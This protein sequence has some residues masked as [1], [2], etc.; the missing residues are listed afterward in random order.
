MTK[1]K[2]RSSS[3]SQNN[4]EADCTRKWGYSSISYLPQT[5]NRSTSRGTALHDQLEI[6]LDVDENG[7]SRRTGKEPQMFPKGWEIQKDYFSRLTMPT[8]L[9]LRTTSPVQIST[10]LRSPILST[11][12]TSE[13]MCSSSVMPIGGPKSIVKCR[14]NQY[15]MR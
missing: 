11:R 15:P 6:H 2:P 5:P 1:M 10:T 4:T 14:E 12:D 9:T 13:T 3:V 7:I 8:V